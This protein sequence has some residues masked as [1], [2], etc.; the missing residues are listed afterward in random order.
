MYVCVVCY[1]RFES[2]DILNIHK[3]LHPEPKQSKEMKVEVKGEETLE[4]DP[5]SIKMEAE[6]VEEIIKQE[7]EDTVQE[8]DPLSCEQNSDEDKI[9]TIDIVENKIEMC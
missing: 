8:E 3:Y 1:K 2:K 7:M 6:N 4:V 9:N 5:L